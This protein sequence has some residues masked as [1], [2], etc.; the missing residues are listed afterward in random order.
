MKTIILALLMVGLAASLAISDDVMTPRNASIGENIFLRDANGRLYSTSYPVPVAL[1]SSGS[2]SLTIKDG[3]QALQVSDPNNWTLNLA[4]NATL[5]TMR[6][7]ANQMNAI[8]L[9]IQSY[10]S[11]I[12]LDANNMD[13]NLAAMR[14][15]QF[16]P[17]DGNRIEK[18]IVDKPVV[19]D[20]NIVNRII[21]LEALVGVTN[22]RLLDSNYP[23]ADANLPYGLVLT[24]VAVA[25]G[26]TN[27]TRLIGPGGAGKVHYVM[28]AALTMYAGDANVDFVTSWIDPNYSLYP[29]DANYANLADPNVTF[30]TMNFLPLYW[31]TAGGIVLPSVENPHK[32]WF[33]TEPNSP[34]W[35]RSNRLVSGMVKV[36]T[37]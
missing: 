22:A 15:A 14:A 7:D 24:N 8:L 30:S 23:T 10:D 9:N 28:Q 21:A 25:R 4:R 29:T 13:V 5:T 18:A 35:L 34:L 1:V 37:K 32:S 3:N 33:K 16:T 31:A 27:Y 6:Q 36:G 26:S 11:S 2:L 20:S 12:Y 19:A 17:L